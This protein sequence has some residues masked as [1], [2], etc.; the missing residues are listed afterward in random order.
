MSFNYAEISSTTNPDGSSTMTAG[1]TFTTPPL[2]PPVQSGT[3]LI[4]TTLPEPVPTLPFP[5]AIFNT[6]IA[7]S[8]T[9]DSNSAAIVS[10]LLAQ[11]NDATVGLNQIQM[12]AHLGG[13]GAYYLSAGGEPTVPVI[14]TNTPADDVTEQI[15][16]QVPIPDF[17]VGTASLCF[18]IGVWQPTTHQIWEFAHAA[19]LP[20]LTWQASRGALLADTGSGIDPVGL[21]PSSSGMSLWGL[22]IK[23]AELQAGVIHHAVGLS[24]PYLLPG[25]EAPAVNGT[26]L[27]GDPRAILTGTHFQLIP[28]TSISAMSA[29]GQIVATA[30]ETYGAY[31]IDTNATALSILCEDPGQYQIDPYISLFAGTL[32]AAVLDNMPVS[33]FRVIAHP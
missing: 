20:S 29:I 11:W 24:L 25:F 22:S 15:F 32:D 3:P 10:N 26:G 21:Y 27:S 1:A 28:G 33:S 9:L 18:G 30:I 31:V 5:G 12:A 19:Y 17:A 6:A 7:G 14:I 2:A 13:F 4:A 16:G 8:P 23:V